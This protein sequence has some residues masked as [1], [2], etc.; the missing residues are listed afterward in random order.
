MQVL[1]PLILSSYTIFTTKKNYKLLDLEVA[2]YNWRKCQRNK[3]FLYEFSF[4]RAICFS[5]ISF[6]YMGEDTVWR[7]LHQS[8]RYY[9]HSKNFTLVFDSVFHYTRTKVKQP[10][11]NA[12]HAFLKYFFGQI[13]FSSTYFKKNFYLYQNWFFFVWGAFF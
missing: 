7:W 12:C 1:N 13:V 3:I 5:F 8:K 11:I 2:Y 4:K 10:L 9:K 6:F